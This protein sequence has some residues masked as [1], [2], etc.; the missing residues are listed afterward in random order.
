MPNKENTPAMPP[1]SHADPLLARL[2]AE[3]GALPAEDAIRRALSDPRL[4]RIALVSS[5]GA[6]SV[7]LL[8]LIR[9]PCTGAIRTPAAI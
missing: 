5:F 3:Y 1:E 7:V 6:Q 8:H 2:N 4:G 9:A